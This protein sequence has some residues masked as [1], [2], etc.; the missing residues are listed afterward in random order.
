MH[1]VI[2]YDVESDKR[3]TKMANKLK[4]HGT[5]V[6]YSVF[7]LESD[8]ARLREI[9]AELRKLMQPRTDRLH[10]FR[11]CEACYLRSD[12]YEPSAKSK[13]AKWEG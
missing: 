11:L 7:E 9:V 10:V 12:A 5:R 13:S 2:A 4:D 1:Y 3:R 8:E 6:Q